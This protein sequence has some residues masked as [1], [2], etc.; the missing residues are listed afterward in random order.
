MVVSRSL[1]W[2][3]PY[4]SVRAWLH[5]HSSTGA[6]PCYRWGRA[7]LRLGTCGSQSSFS[8]AGS[9]DAPSLPRY[10]CSLGRNST[11]L[12]RIAVQRNS[13]R[14]ADCGRH[15]RAK[16]DHGGLHL[17]TVYRAKVENRKERGNECTL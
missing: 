8:G 6:V 3:S 17:G 16:P 11:V 12:E 15:A 9:F 14:R 13:K 1:R 2:A 10:F 4:N 5:L 7:S